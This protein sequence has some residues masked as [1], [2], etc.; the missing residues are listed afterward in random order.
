MLWPCSNIVKKLDCER[1]PMAG[2]DGAPPLPAAPWSVA[3]PDTCFIVKDRADDRSNSRT[4][5]WR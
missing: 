5:T 4:V 3:E 1:W 2:V